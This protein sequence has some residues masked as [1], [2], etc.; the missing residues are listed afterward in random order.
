MT[1]GAA[2]FD[3]QSRCCIS[4]FDNMHGGY[5]LSFSSSENL[6]SS[7]IVMALV[8]HSSA[9]MPQPLQYSRSNCRRYRSGDDNF[10]AEQPADETGFFISFAGNAQALIQNRTLHSPGTGSSAVAGTVFAVR[11][12]SSVISGAHFQPPVTVRS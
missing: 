1:R 3:A 11:C 5:S 8:G 12:F 2:E 6:A 9:Q 10:R 4:V 7:T